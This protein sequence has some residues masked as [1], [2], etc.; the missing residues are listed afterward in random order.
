MFP[1]KEKEIAVK[2][3]IGRPSENQRVW[4]LLL[5]RHL[6]LPTASQPQIYE[7]STK[8]EKH[9]NITNVLGVQF[10]EKC[11]SATIVNGTNIS[12]LICKLTPK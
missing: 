12:I 7:Q 11:P 8:Y 3:K 4:W 2:K 10:S 9:P 5:S 1:R 6:T